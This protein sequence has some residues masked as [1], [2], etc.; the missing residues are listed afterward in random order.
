METLNRKLGKLG[1]VCCCHRLENNPSLNDNLEELKAEKDKL[2]REIQFTGFQLNRGY[3]SPIKSENQHKKLQDRMLGRYFVLICYLILDLRIEWILE[4]LTKDTFPL[5]KSLKQRPKDKEKKKNS[6][7]TYLSKS[8]F[9]EGLEKEEPRKQE[10]EDYSLR[11]Q[12]IFENL[13]DFEKKNLLTDM[14]RCST[15]A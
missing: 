15:L 12:K 5:K 3:S 4:L 13:S 7:F 9:I 2:I 1:R 8:F 14:L 10:S 11:K 6:A